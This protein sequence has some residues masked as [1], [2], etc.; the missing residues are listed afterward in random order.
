MV[1]SRNVTFT[2]PSFTSLN[3]DD[4]AARPHKSALQLTGFGF[5][6]R[7]RTEEKGEGGR[8]REEKR[9]G[10]RRREEKGEGGRR[11]ECSALSSPLQ[12]SFP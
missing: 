4:S 8:R 1:W 5:Q 9:E 2:F 10:G 11:R 6:V 7:S 12:L 3:V